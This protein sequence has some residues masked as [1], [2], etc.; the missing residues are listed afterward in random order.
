MPPKKVTPRGK[1]AKNTA[2]PKAT[3]KQKPAAAPRKRGSTKRF[4]RAIYAPAGGTRITL[5]N[6]SRFQLQPRGQIGDLAPVDKDDM[7]DPIY[8]QNKGVMFEEISEAEAKKIMEKQSTNAQ[9][10][11]QASVLSQI[12][13]EYGNPMKQSVKV[14][15]PFEQQGQVV[16]TVED[17]AP[18]RF[19]DGHQ[20]L[21]TRSE[22][23]MAPDQQVV[24]GSQGHPQQQQVPDNV[25]PEQAADW[26][27]RNTEQDAHATLRA[28]VGPTQRE[29]T[30]TDH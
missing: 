15:Q 5:N 14:E 9:A 22:G 4:I 21:I 3:G 18:G 8:H 12:R 30:P 6:G 27:A 29:I 7:N 20:G 13:D 24:P 17:S 2:S 19:T 1:A 28:S 11:R 10:P 16:A 26:L 25:P 23:G